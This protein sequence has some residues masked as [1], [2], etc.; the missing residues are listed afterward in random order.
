MPGDEPLRIECEHFL[1]CL[2]TRHDPGP[3]A[4]SALRVLQVSRELRALGTANGRPTEIGQI[5]KYCPS[6]RSRRYRLEIGDG[7]QI[8]HFSHVMSGSKIGPHCNLG[9]NVVI[10]PGVV[11]GNNVKIQ[12]N[13]SVYTG[14]NPRRR[15]ASAVRP[16]YLP[17]WSTRA[18]TSRRKNEY[19]APLVR[20]GASHRRQ[21]D[22]RM[23][24]HARQVRFIAAGAVVT[25]NVPDYAIMA[26]VPGTSMGWMCNADRRL[27]EAKRKLHL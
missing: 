4:D 15:R 19:R 22:H 18:A 13:V 20:Q 5:P 16:W 21:F 27:A 25:K 10:S 17:T 3:T 26:G 14:V 9:Q 24:R 8:W 2:R 23:R 12:N 1:E 11:I 6:H 7:T